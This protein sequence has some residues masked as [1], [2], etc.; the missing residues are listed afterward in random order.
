MQKTKSMGTGTALVV[1]VLSFGVFA[2]VA[3]IVTKNQSHITPVSLANDDGEDNGGSSSSESAKK[4]AEKSKEADKKQSEQA[5][6]SSKQQSE[7]SREASKQQFERTR[8]T[9]KQQFEI[10]REANKKK[11]ELSGNKSDSVDTPEDKT[12]E[13]LNGDDTEEDNNGMFKD[14]NKTLADLNEKLAE[15]QK[16]ILEKQAEGQDVTVALANLALAK[17]KLAGVNTSFDSN[18]LEAAKELAKEIKKTAQFTEKDI[19]FAKDSAEAVGEVSDKIGEVTKKIAS[20]EAL[21]G[22]ASV[23][24]AQLAS[25]Q[26][27]FATLQSSGATTRETVKAFEKKAERLKSLIERSSFALGG[28]DGEDLISDHEKDSENLVEDLNDVAD[29]E[30]GDNNGVAKEVKTVALEHKVASQD[31]KKSLEDI[32]NRGGVERVILGPDF[33]ALDSLNGQ[34]TAMNTRA[35]ALAGAAG[36]ITDPQI[37]Q[38]LTD[39]VAALRSE[40]AKLQAYVSSEGNQFSIFGKL[41][42]F[43]R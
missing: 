4:D 15:A 3:S 28:T 34:I 22:D 17:S 14:K 13:H 35:D 25:L 36:K 27:D 41:L 5:K 21:G 24:K 26:A 10:A 39:R 9:E 43:F 7:Q 23:Y 38:I 12:G 2:G 42:S 40:A 6:E 11:N 18:N 31:I 30:D 16:H 29:I 20:L 37:K 32:Q 19:E 1:A 8:E 33:N